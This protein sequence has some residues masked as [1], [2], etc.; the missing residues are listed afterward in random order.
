MTIDELLIQ[1]DYQHISNVNC[2]DVAGKVLVQFAKSFQFWDE[3]AH[4]YQFLALFNPQT[5]VIKAIKLYGTDLEAVVEWVEENNSYLWCP[6]V[7]YIKDEQTM[8][9]KILT[10]TLICSLF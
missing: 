9:R 1:F 7:H 2:D 5:K 4:I 6:V 3:K 10:L 8:P